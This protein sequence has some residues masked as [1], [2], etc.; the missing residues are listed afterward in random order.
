[1]TLPI[2]NDLVLVCQQIIRENKSDD[3]WSEIES[4]DMFQQGSIHGGYEALERAFCFSYYAPTGEE[5]WF[6]ITLPEVEQI[7]NGQ[8]QSVEARPAG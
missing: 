2:P 8:K 7:V 5:L 4:G 6:Q 1:M 3:Q